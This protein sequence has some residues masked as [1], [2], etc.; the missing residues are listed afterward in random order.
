MA[1][2]GGG[3]EGTVGR[4]GTGR[5]RAAAAGVTPAAATAAVRT[6]ERSNADPVR[7]R[8]REVLDMGTSSGRFS[9][10]FA[11]GGTIPSLRWHHPLNHPGRGASTDRVHTRRT[12]TGPGAC[13]GTG[14]RG[15]ARDR[16]GRDG[17]GGR[18]GRGSL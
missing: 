10:H 8:L 2:P 12:R 17:I 9:V 11:G 18:R 6:M 7:S 4:P 16:R 1:G 15:P 5:G 13:A 14:A 3:P